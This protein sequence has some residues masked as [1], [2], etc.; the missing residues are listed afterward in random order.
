METTSRSLTPMNGASPFAG[1]SKGFSE[2]DLSNGLAHIA[3]Q[4]SARFG[5]GPVSGSP[6]GSPSLAA[7]TPKVMSRAQ[8]QWHTKKQRSSSSKGRKASVA[9]GSRKKAAAGALAIVGG[10]DA[11]EVQS[12]FGRMMSVNA[13][14]SPSKEAAAVWKATPVLQPEPGSPA[15]APPQPPRRS[16]TN[17]RGGP[18]RSLTNAPG[19]APAA[20]EWLDQLGALPPLQKQSQTPVGRAPKE[21][22]KG[23]KLRRTSSLTA[24]DTAELKMFT[25]L[26]KFYRPDDMGDTEYKAYQQEPGTHYD[27]TSLL[28][29]EAIRFDPG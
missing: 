1:L 11:H 6:P 21:K 13:L 5:S 12:N 18:R 17:A 29:R 9:F 26:N 3:T 14:Q 20:D 19:V 23:M 2:R 24:L 27:E 8:Q 4:A 28:K 10:G 22:P 7:L 16:L 25:E 15:T